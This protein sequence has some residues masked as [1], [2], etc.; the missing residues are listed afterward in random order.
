MAIYGPEHGYRGEVEAGEHVQSGQDQVTGLPV[1]SLYGDN[2]KPTPAMLAGIEALVFDIQDIGARYYTYV[3]TMALGMEA[4]GEAGIPFIVLDRPNPIG[5]AVQGNVLDPAYSTFVGMYP[6]PM[7]H[8]LTPGELARLFLSEFSVDVD[9]SVIPVD[10]WV[11]DMSVRGDRDAVDR[12]FPQHARHGQR[13]FTTLER[14]CSRVRI[15]RLAAGRIV[16]SNKSVRP[17]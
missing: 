1:H 9:L 11:R 10:G 8:G 15:Y 5:G 16:R 2:R 12:P 14:A 3:S 17:G 6:I 13:A 7:R 4:A